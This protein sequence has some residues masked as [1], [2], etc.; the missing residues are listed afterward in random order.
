MSIQIS[1]KTQESSANK[2]TDQEQK[3]Q[4]DESEAS[5]KS[6]GARKLGGNILSLGSGEIT[7]R[8]IAFFGVTYAAR[9]LGPEQFGIIGFAAALFGYLS[10]AVTAGFSDIGS[11]EVARR[12]RDAASIGANVVAVKI[13]LAFVAL[14]AIAATAWFLDKPPT[15]KLVL[16]SMGLLF[17]PLALDTSWVYKG[18]ERN[19]PVA[20]S[21]IIGQV[22]YAGAI[23]LSVNESSDV[24]FVPL[25]Q[26]FGELC[27]ALMLALPLFYLNKIKLD[28][29]EGFRILR[30]SGYWAI[31][32]LLR[33]VMYTFDVVLIGFLLGE[34]AVGLY[35]AP[36][37]ICF[38][39]VALA[40]AIHTS[41]LP[42]IIRAAHPASA[43]P[44][45]GI[46]AER[47]L[48]FAAAVAAPLVV[49]GI[50]V[51]APLLEAVFGGGY[52]EGSAAFQYL[53]LSIGLVFL[54]G[55]IH[56]I[57]LAVN[58]LKT[59]M[60]IFAAAAAFNIGLNILV[61]PR[62]GIVGAAFV[63]ALAEGLTLILGL[64]VVNRIG[65]RFSLRPIWRPLLASLVM[66]AVLILL[67][68]NIG[69]IWQIVAGAVSYL[70]ALI[71]LDGIPPD[72]RPFFHMPALVDNTRGNSG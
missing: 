72:A 25:A 60:T 46:V 16:L 26:F 68:A 23:F 38:L 11:R 19:R 20:L 40:V 64:I 66:G 65:A 51:A 41:Y 62:Y 10:L 27:A 48:N 31:S 69:L 56:N 36:Y 71:L 35:T 67:G 5:G 58:R 53:I 24:A 17:F 44:E 8:L 28:L 49:G 14:I 42:I 32:R 37:R 47:S 18:L 45:V 12:P 63:T 43:L 1:D 15:V 52:T 2:T 57:F 61:V 6:S 34:Q 9:L 29:R 55:A 3:E 22:L 54:Y 59:E 21:L 13:I 33:T 50:I 7:A 30:S 70:L 4:A 39:L